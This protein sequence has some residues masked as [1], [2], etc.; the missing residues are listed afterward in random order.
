MH[1]KCSQS[2]YTENRRVLI[3]SENRTVSCPKLLSSFFCRKI[4]RH[5]LNLQKHSLVKENLCFVHCNRKLT[6]L[7][8][9]KWNID[10][11]KGLSYIFHSSWYSISPSVESN[12]L[13]FFYQS[14]NQH[15]VS[16]ILFFVENTS[17]ISYCFSI[18]TT[19]AW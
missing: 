11:T 19:E 4:N 18:L 6:N 3:V 7:K 9:Q 12:C 2:K 5:F 10:T 13:E 14:L 16:T 8:C 17:F 15:F 1:W